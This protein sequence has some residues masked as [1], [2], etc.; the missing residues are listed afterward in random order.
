M[1]LVD[2]T[3]DNWL[4]VVFLS[5]TDKMPMICEEFVAS[6][7]LSLVQA[8]YEK[9]WITKAIEVDTVLVGF[10]M[11]GKEPDEEQY[12]ICRLMIDYKY[13]GKGYGRKAMEIILA[14]LKS[15][16]DGLDIYLS[17]EPQNIVAKKLYESCGFISTNRI[18]DGE[19]EFVLKNN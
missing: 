1:E 12:T 7:A 9:N 3:K 10:T 5:T 6:N 17:V 13:Q 14:A 16:Q 11:Y 2:I 15:K 19:E 4:D 8:Q 18:V